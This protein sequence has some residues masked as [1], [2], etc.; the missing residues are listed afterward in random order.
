MTKTLTAIFIAVLAVLLFA[1]TAYADSD[2]D[3]SAASAS[4]QFEATSSNEVYLMIG[5][6]ATIDTLSWSSLGVPTYTEIQDDASTDVAIEVDV[7][8]TDATEDC[9]LTAVGTDL[10]SGG[11]TIPISDFTLTASGEFTFS[12]VALANGSPVTLETLATSDQYTGT[13]IVEYDDST[14]VPPGSYASALA[15]SVIFTATIQ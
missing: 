2:T 6:A 11:N 8:V 9:V 10:S 12:S 7:T 1:G 15:A 13:F 3:S 4:L 14:H 5:N